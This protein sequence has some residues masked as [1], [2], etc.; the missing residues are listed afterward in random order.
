MVTDNKIT[1]KK[2][3]YN[4]IRETVKTSALL[5]GSIEKHEYLSGGEILSSDQSRMI[6]QATLT[7]VPLGKAF[8]NQIKATEGQ[9]KNKLRP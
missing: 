5:S 8:E 3:Q 4:I 2:L 9:G 1:D 6:D 7:H